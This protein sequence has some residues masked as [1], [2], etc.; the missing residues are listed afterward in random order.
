MSS[1]PSLYKIAKTRLDQNAQTGFD[2]R[3]KM[4]LKSMDNNLFAN[5]NFL[6][7][8]IKI[9]EYI[10][11]WVSMAKQIKVFRNFA[12]PPDHEDIN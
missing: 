2:Y 6:G 10:N 1:I 12:V 3:G 9:E 4:L 11:E 8:A 5:E 7:F